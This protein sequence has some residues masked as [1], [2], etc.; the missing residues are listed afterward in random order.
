MVR[1]SVYAVKLNIWINKKMK[2]DLQKVAKEEGRTVSDIIRSLLVDY[3]G[4][5]N[6]KNIKND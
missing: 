3:L 4:E 5:K 1:P 2:S 6:K